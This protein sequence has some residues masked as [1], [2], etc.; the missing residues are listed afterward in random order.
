MPLRQNVG[1]ALELISQN[2]PTRLFGLDR[3]VLRIGRD[4]GSDVVLDDQRVSR[5]H[6]HVLRKADGFFVEDLDSHNLTYLDDRMLAPKT[7]A[8]LRDGSRVSICDHHLIFRQAAVVI[9]AEGPGDSAVLKT[10]DDPGTMTP[11]TRLDRP[12]DVLRAVLEIN[13]ALGGVGELNEALNRTLKA[14]FDVFSQAECGF[15]LT[16]EADGRLNPRAL[17]RRDGEGRP[18]ALSRTVLDHVMDA[19]KALLIADAQAD[20]P[21]RVSDTLA[22]S[23]IRTVLCV[24]LPGRAGRPIGILQLDSRSRRARFGPDDLDL[25]ATAA[26]PIGMAIE[27]YRLLKARAEGAA[28][29]EIQL[30][31]L[32]RHRPDIARYALWEHYEPALEVG[33]DYYDYIPIGTPGDGGHADAPAPGAGAG[34]RWAIAVGDVAGKGMPAALMMAHLGAEVRHQAR[35][36]SDPRRIVEGINGHFCDADLRDLFITFVLAVIDPATHRLTV[37]NAGHPAPLLR[38][39]GGSVE[40]IGESERGMPLTVMGGQAY[41]AITVELGPADVVVFYS[42]GI[43]EALDR[44][45]KLFGNDEVKATLAAAPAGARAAGEAILEA[46]RAHTGSRNRSDDITLIC[47]GRE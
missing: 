27:N 18:P 19:G 37:V 23:G 10:L 20:L 36:H 46:V 33:G 5:S 2:G 28:A 14:L 1:P 25:L 17:R 40:V 8:P 39:A 47:L 45:G 38:R 7:P 43:N 22:D 13:R 24:P 11:E 44:H 16:E 21:F 26:I 9:R 6:A 35:A 4:S 31:L 3:D 15:I 34:D 30:A 42:D 12:R 29:R 41:R 32:P